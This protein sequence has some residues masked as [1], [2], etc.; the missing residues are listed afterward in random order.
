M[1]DIE[2]RIK[3]YYLKKSLTDDQID[4]VVNGKKKH[5]ASKSYLRYAAVLAFLL[6]AVGAYQF[7][8]IYQKNAMLD[9]FA[10]EV[11]MN[12]QKAL[13]SDFVTNSVDELN[14]KMNQLDFPIKMPADLYQ[15]YEL[16]G[17]RYCSVNQKIAAQLKLKNSAGKTTTLYI[18]KKQIDQNIQRTTLVDTVN[19][20]I[21]NVESL[22][23]LLVKPCNE[24]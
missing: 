17:G 23:Y 3:A 6:V 20:H 5:W 9:S 12:H 11:A 4:K 24:K 22:M 18:T 16:L 21:W 15:D 10:Q 13:K 19:V 14:E 2:D 7:Y 1:K 8:G